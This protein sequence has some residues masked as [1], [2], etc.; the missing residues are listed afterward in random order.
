MLV[1][2][3]PAGGGLVAIAATSWRRLP[4]TCRRHAGDAEGRGQPV[5]ALV[6][7]ST[8]TPSALGAA[9][10][11]TTT[12]PRTWRCPR[13]PPSARA[14]APCRTRGAASCVRGGAGQYPHHSDAVRRGR[15]RGDASQRP[16]QPE[17]QGR[18][19]AGAVRDSP[20]AAER[21]RRCGF[22]CPSPARGARSR[23]AQ[24]L[25]TARRE[26]GEEGGLDSCRA[27]RVSPQMNL[28]ECLPPY[29]SMEPAV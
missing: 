28:I 22:T 27:K 5:A 12:T 15:V 10:T 19:G 20:E 1:R 9:T 11:T 3:G 14:S 13:C 17:P 21:A 4:A 29:G 24:L 23:E 16:E 26:E 7:D 2:C 8:P 6:P 18:A 25:I